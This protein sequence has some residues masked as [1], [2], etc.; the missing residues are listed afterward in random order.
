LEV[1]SFK[2][3]QLIRED[4]NVPTLNFV[5]CGAA[6]TLIGTPGSNPDDPKDFFWQHHAAMHY[7]L[8]CTKFP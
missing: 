5:N 6:I 8:L 3:R 1:G 7:K 2:T 4:I